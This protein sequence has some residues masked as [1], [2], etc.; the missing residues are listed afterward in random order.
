MINVCSTQI[1]DVAVKYRLPAIFG[2]ATFAEAGG[3]MAYGPNRIELWR[4]PQFSW[5]RF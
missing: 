3:L 4:G 5:T 1:A 2:L